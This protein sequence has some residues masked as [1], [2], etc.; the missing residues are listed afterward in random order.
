MVGTL[1]VPLHFYSQDQA[2][3]LERWNLTSF[4]S[5]VWMVLRNLGHAA[6]AVGRVGLVNDTVAREDHF[7]ARATAVLS[8]TRGITLLGACSGVK[9][10]RSRTM[11]D[12][13]IRTYVAAARTVPAITSSPPMTKVQRAPATSPIQPITGAPNGVPPITMVM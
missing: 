1:V 4:R 10:A 13:A 6:P 3:C 8:Q 12:F 7:R 11:R 5:S 9:M 2:I